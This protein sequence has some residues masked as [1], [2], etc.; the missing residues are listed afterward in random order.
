M[1]QDS[2]AKTEPTTPGL[3][4]NAIDIVTLEARKEG[5]FAG[6]TGGLASGE[7]PI[8]GI[9]SAETKQSSVVFVSITTLVLQIIPFYARLFLLTFVLTVTGILSGYFFTEA[10]KT[11]HIAQLHAEEARLRA[12]T[13]ETPNSEPHST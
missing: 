1:D 10:F 4:P 7:Y 8:E 3:P 13:N 6:L 9:V 12:R 5:V 11:A 2:Q